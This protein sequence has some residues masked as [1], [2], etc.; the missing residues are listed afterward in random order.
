MPTGNG[1]ED[2]LLGII[3]DLLYVT[4]DFFADLQ[5]TGLKG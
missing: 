2:D 3:T 5:E 4:L 1:A